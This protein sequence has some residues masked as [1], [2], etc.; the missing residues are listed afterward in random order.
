MNDEEIRVNPWMAPEGAS[1]RRIG[2]VE[3]REEGV[4][5]TE[6]TLFKAYKAICRAGVTPEFAEKIINEMQNAGILFRE[7][8]P[9]IIQPKTVITRSGEDLTDPKGANS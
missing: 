4:Y 8:V 5:F 9:Q 2:K 6:E 7:R 3:F 1:Y